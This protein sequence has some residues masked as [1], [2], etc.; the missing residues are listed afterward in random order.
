MG[1]NTPASILRRSRCVIVGSGMDTSSGGST[2]HVPRDGTRNAERDEYGFCVAFRG[3][4]ERYFRGAKGDSFAPRQPLSAHAH[5][6]PLN[7][8]GFVILGAALIS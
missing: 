6:H 7:R 3:A 4:I 2:R 8:Q 1:I 5:F